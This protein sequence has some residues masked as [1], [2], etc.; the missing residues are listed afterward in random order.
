M[1]SLLD[2]GSVD[3]GNRLESAAYE[4]EK[5]G[6]VSFPQ[7]WRGMFELIQHI[8]RSHQEDYL[9]VLQGVIRS[10]GFRDDP[11][12]QSTFTDLKN[13]FESSIDELTRIELDCILVGI[14]ATKSPTAHSMS[15]NELH[16]LVKA[17]EPIF[18]NH[19]GCE[20]MVRLLIS[21]L[22]LK[23][24]GKKERSPHEHPQRR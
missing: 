19:W 6:E 7:N 8:H 3:G 20:S 10:F 13:L 9:Y 4:C 17:F 16:D 14:L 21:D 23:L 12:I 24:D 1:R 5:C 11:V 18:R 22:Q 15:R 2:G